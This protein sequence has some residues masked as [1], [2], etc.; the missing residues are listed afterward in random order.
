[1]TP[2][3]PAYLLSL[4]R[5]TL[6]LLLLGVTSLARADDMASSGDPLY[7]NGGVGQEEADAIRAQAAGFNL[8]LYL[9]AGKAGK[10]ITGVSL[11]VTDSK[12]N[13][14][15]QLDD[16]GPMLFT[17]VAPGNYR[18]KAD[19]NGNTLSRNISVA[20]RK[21]SNVYLNFREAATD[22]QDSS[23]PDPYSGQ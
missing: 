11:N 20:G 5:I 13:S 4:A 17:R 23:A 16:A 6:P 18:I 3:R 22:M 9:S 15:V 7:I 1:M 8:R 14:V 12:G 21:G 19:Y 10:S 2:S